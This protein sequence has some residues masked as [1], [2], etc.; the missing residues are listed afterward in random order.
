M[1]GMMGW[2][3]Q[4]RIV[5]MRLRLFTFV[6]LL[7]IGT[8]LGGWNALQNGLL[9]P[10]CQSA[11]ALSEALMHLFGGGVVRAGTVLRDPQTQKAIMVSWGCSGADATFIL[12]SA[13]LVYPSC[14][15][16]KAQGL[17]AG[18][19]ALQGLNVARII[20]LFHLNNWSEQLFN[21]AHLY[22]WQGLLMLDV[23]VFM[24][25]WLRWQK[26]QCRLA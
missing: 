22:L 7:G 23:L 17:V 19:L 1:G 6:T 18:F 13:I 11:A 15:W 10:W 9:E 21:F 24:L 16:A 12:F 4:L 8:V 3:L 2:I 25:I 26:T 5:S 20:T 14:W